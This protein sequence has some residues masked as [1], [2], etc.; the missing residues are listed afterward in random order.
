MLQRHGARLC[1]KKYFSPMQGEGGREGEA[2]KR[3]YR[4]ISCSTMFG[5]R[6]AEKDR[7]AF[8]HLASKGPRGRL[9]MS[10]RDGDGEMVRKI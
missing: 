9:R 6:T 5:I 3:A 7:R 1:H 4:S 8:E 10:E 2:E